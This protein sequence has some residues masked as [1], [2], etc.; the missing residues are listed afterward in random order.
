MLNL[1]FDINS[2]KSI[3]KKAVKI[4]PVVIAF[5]PVIALAQ[6]AV[7][8][9]LSSSG[10]GALFGNGLAQDKTLPELIIDVVALLLL[11]AG[12]IAVLFVI[13][14]GYFYITAQGNEEQSEKG[15][16]TLINAIIG[17]IVVIMSYAI[18]NVISNTIAN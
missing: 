12:A 3:L 13:I 8:H 4:L 1:I 5:L 15:K 14:G 2:M 17:V 18:I 10:F 7:G 6:G 16:K 11:F 9:G